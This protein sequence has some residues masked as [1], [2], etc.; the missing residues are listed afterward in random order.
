MGRWGSSGVLFLF[1]FLWL[2]S[3]GAKGFP[4][5]DL[6]MRLP[7]QPPVSFKQYAGYVDI[8]LKNG[9]SL[10]YYFV[11]A[12]EQPEKKPLTLWLNGGF[13]TSILYVFLNF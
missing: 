6:V 8:D 12:E 7:G 1:G 4:S 10:F 5:E 2:L 3:G 13:L 9:R 11:E